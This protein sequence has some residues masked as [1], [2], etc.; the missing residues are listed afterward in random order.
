MFI[1]PSFYL[2]YWQ[3][4]IL[5]S[6]LLVMTAAVWTYLHFHYQIVNI[7]HHQDINLNQ[8]LTEK[9]L[10]EDW[11]ALNMRRGMHRVRTKER[12]VDT[13]DST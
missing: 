12:K 3:T 9:A 2:I 5:I 7:Y 10:H 4:I 8:Q 6:G 1:N 11:H 13:P